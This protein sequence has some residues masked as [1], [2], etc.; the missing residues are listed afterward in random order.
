MRNSPY[1]A[2]AFRPDAGRLAISAPSGELTLWD[3]ADPTRP[4]A[5]GRLRQGRG[6]VAAAWNPAV[7]D[8]LATTSS[9]GSGAV[10]WLRDD[11]P[12][13]LFAS[14][15][16][17][18]ERP[19]HVGW[20]AGGA[21][22]FSMTANGGTSV[23]DVRS[24]ACVGR[25]NVSGGRRVLA[26]H[27]RGEEVVVITD[28]GWARLWH[29]RRQPGEWIRLTARPVSA[30]TWSTSQLV[31]A[32]AD[33]RLDCFDADFQA[34]DAVPGAREPARALACSDD[35]R[36]FVS[37]GEDRAVAV[38]RDG[39]VRW[40]IPLDPA[41]TRSVQIAGDLIAVSGRP[42]RPTLLALATGEAY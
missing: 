2:M 23:W 22:V 29:P 13:E 40:K 31:L 24:G 19:R 21:W 7:T 16:A 17:L 28:S 1:G 32:G 14:W 10:W 34:V 9:D 30:C 4:K 8:M 5:A 18:P 15:A 33:G 11:R 27:Y 42:L 6:I 3:T 25:V 26:A 35:G 12:P 39:S 37:F 41:A 36:L 38:G 20:V